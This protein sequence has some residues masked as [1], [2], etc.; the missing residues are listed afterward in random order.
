MRTSSSAASK[1]E[2]QFATRIIRHPMFGALV[3]YE[4]ARLTAE[5]GTPVLVVES[6][7][8]TVE[9][10]GYPANWRTLS[11]AALLRALAKKH[12]S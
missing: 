3:I 7:D 9:V 4:S 10:T 2:P 6:V 1:S 11:D 12:R 5:R 8:Q